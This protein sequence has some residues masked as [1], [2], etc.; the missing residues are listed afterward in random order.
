MNFEA[1]FT[2]LVKVTGY[3]APPKAPQN[4]ISKIL[5]KQ[6]KKSQV[7]CLLHSPVYIREKNMFKFL[8]LDKESVFKEGLSMANFK[9]GLNI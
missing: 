3:L 1:V 9:V 8:A 6:T 5:N 2:D 7:D 4:A